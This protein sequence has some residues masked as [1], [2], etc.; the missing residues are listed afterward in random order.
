[1]SSAYGD[2]YAVKMTSG[3]LVTCDSAAK[4]ILLHL[5]SMRDGPYKFMIRD[6]DETH[7]MIKREY[8]EEIKELLQDELEK[9]TY[10]QDPNM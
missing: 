8:V 2:A 4:Q 3:V 1:M 9:N 10:I 5:D 6:V 7:I